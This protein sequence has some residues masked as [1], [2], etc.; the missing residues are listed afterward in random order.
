[1]KVECDCLAVSQIIATEAVKP[2]VL[3]GTIPPL[4]DILQIVRR[5]E[6]VLLHA[7]ANTCDVFSSLEKFSEL[8]NC[9]VRPN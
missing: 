4:S 6:E 3:H 8:F 7:L 2:N 1:L 9:P 5:Y